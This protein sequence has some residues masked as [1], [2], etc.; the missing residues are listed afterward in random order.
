[1]LISFAVLILLIGG[2]CAV[3]AAFGVGCGLPHS[4]DVASWHAAMSV[5]MAAMIL[6]PGRAAL[7]ALGLVVFLVGAGWSLWRLATGLG[8][9][10]YISLTVGC[11]AMVA[12]L[13]PAAA[14]ALPASPGLSGGSMEGTS[15]TAMAGMTAVTGAGAVV[16]AAFAGGLLAVAVV[17]AARA[18]RTHTGLALL[19]AG[20][21][22][23]MAVSMA[24]M[25][26]VM[27]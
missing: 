12:M 26:L 7:S 17:T 27:L 23:V 21:E 5:G 19:D 24:G 1:M 22:T 11:A 6:W 18:V 10:V 3:R 14:S 15:G 9:T 8:R 4:R 25:L 20:C 2:Y 16:F 13:V